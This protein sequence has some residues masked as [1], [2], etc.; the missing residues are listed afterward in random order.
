V[1][2]N[3]PLPADS[4]GIPYQF[5]TLILGLACILGFHAVYWI[6]V[7]SITMGQ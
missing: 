4:N 2:E 3:K 1:D 5:R 6:F 7:F